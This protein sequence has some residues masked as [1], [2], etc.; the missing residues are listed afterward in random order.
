VPAAPC[1]HAAAQSAW[2]FAGTRK[3]WEALEGASGPKTAQANPNTPGGHL[4]Q[5]PGEGACVS[6][7][8]AVRLARS[9]NER[10]GA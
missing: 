10:A 9:K 1:T 2:P 5:T 3:L 7:V 4:N 8:A 6:H